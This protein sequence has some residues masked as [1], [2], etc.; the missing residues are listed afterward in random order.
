MATTIPTVHMH[1]LV[2]TSLFCPSPLDIGVYL[3]RPLLDDTKA[4]QQY[5]KTTHLHLSLLS[6]LSLFLL[7]LARRFGDVGTSQSS[8]TVV[9][10]A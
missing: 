2:H 1:P 7:S 4:V 6:L 5:R 10:R 3:L 8:L 9:I